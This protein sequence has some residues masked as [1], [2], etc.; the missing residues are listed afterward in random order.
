M[1]SFTNTFVLKFFGHFYAGPVRFTVQNKINLG[2]DKLDSVEVS[3]FDDLK[4]FLM[5]ETDR[6][7]KIKNG[8]VLSPL[9]KKFINLFYHSYFAKG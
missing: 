5:K 7:N 3:G 9:R 4:N 6:S 1:L 2:G 8:P